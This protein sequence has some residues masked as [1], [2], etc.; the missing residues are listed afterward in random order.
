MT[1]RHKVTQVTSQFARLAQETTQLAMAREVEKSSFE[2]IMEMMMTMRME[3][4][5]KQRE[6]D[7]KREQEEKERE[8]TKGRKR[9][10]WNRI[11]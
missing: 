3:D 6:R 7:D 1:F 9:K 10:E 5:S 2:K 4:D 8:R 11:G